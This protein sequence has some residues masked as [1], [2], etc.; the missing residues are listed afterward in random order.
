MLKI[1]IIGLG[2]ISVAHIDAIQHQPDVELVAVCDIDPGKKNLVPSAR[3]YTDIEI[4]CENEQIDCAHV[5]LPH[6]LHVPVALQLAK[7]GIHV[8]LEKPAGL[9]AEDAARLLTAEEIYGV[10][11]GI[12][13]QNRYNNT[14]Q[15]LRKLIEKGTY[16]RLIGMRA[17]V[18]WDRREN[19]YDKD[20]WRG[21]TD[22][23]GGGVMLSQAIHTLDLLCLFGGQVE[24]VSGLSGNLLLEEIE[25]EDTAAGYIRYTN[26]AGAIFYTTVTHCKND[27]IEIE[28]VFEKK[29]LHLDDL[30]LV[31]K[32]DS[33]SILLAENDRIVR[34][35]NYYGAGHTKAIAAFY[36]SIVHGTVE[37][38]T[39]EEAMRSIKLIDAVLQS[40]KT[41]ARVG[42]C[43]K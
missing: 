30:L 5:C 41:K 40:A 32:S 43:L 17:M 42:L 4:M 19:Y 2:V 23:A 33:G 22:Q 20:P 36:R 7:H 13:L 37:Y 6:H 39:V 27:S 26:G 1:A 38:I 15:Y 29:T 12:C 18:A 11:I 34:G 25:V 21:K 10:K 31:E 8:F 24:W 14:T 28:L 35:K 3:F 9:N 16:G